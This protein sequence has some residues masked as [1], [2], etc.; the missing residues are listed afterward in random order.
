M[1]EVLFF[2]DDNENI[3]Y[4]NE[5]GVCAYLVNPNVGCTFKELYNGL[6]K[7]SKIVK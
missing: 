5:I 3:F 6:V 4:T 1:N 2:D 7:Y